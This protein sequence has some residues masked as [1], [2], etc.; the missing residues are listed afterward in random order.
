[1]RKLVYIFLSVLSF[2]E[3][4]AQDIHFS[5]FYMAPLTQNPAMAGAL[6]TSEV[7]FN[8]KNQWNNVTSPYKTFALSAM[9]RVGK[10]KKDKAHWALGLNFFND[11]SG[12]GKLITTNGNFTLALQ[13]P[14]N[15]YNKLGLGLQ[16]GFGQVRINF[17]EF[18]WGS[19]YGNGAYDPNQ[20]SGEASATN[21]F[22]YLDFS[23]GIVWTYNKTAGNLKT[24]NNQF[25]KGSFG[26]SVFHINQP[27]YSFVSSG[28]KLNLKYV[29]HGNYIYS[30]ED[31]KF[32]IN[33]GFMYYRQGPAQQILIGT[34]VRYN[35]LPE[36]K[37]T[38]A[39]NGG[40]VYLGAY[41]R[42]KDAVVLA[43]MFEFSNITLG[44]S[45]DINTSSL[46]TASNGKGGLEF[47]LRIVGQSKGKRFK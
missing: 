21:Q 27:L 35:I 8:Y 12:D 38:G 17:S 7:N 22:G 2:I 18:Q 32:A 36:S 20:I 24:S 13:I 34:M 39:F 6:S 30:F 4:K 31:T 15:R 40:G 45:Y 1:M 25:N 14:I 44:F 19:Q 9:M 11:Q 16:S 28:D 23:S 33:P 10:Y 47:S 5:Q 37:Y 3:L 26:F 43:T 46:R 42:A 29:L 41:V